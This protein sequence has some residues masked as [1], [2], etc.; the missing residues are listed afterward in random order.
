MSEVETSVKPLL[1]DHA[2]NA[3]DVE[4]KIAHLVRDIFPP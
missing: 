3:N 4:I 2:K 1:G